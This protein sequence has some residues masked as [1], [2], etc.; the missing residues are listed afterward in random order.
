MI[1]NES[2]RNGLFD[3]VKGGLLVLQGTEFKRNSSGF[4]NVNLIKTDVTI[5]GCTIEDNLSTGISYSN[6]LESSYN[7]IDVGGSTTFSMLALSSITTP[8]SLGGFFKLNEGVI[9]H[10]VG[11]SLTRGHARKGG[12]I[13]S[14][15]INTLTIEQSTILSF[16]VAEE[17]GGAIFTSSHSLIDIKTLV[18]FTSN[19]SKSLKGS[20]ICSEQS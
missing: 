16:N 10:I 8:N 1:D 3:S 11:G 2:E 15:G 5:T 20:D 9:L 7:K 17:K 13:Y 12:A 6:F 19:E 18:Q 4:S 14:S